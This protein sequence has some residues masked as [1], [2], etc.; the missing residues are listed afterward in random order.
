V[1]Q[2][3]FFTESTVAQHVK[4]GKL[5]ALAVVADERSTAF[6]ELPT[7]K[8]AG[9]APMDVSPWFGIVAPAGTPQP[10]VGKLEAALQRVVD[11][12]EFS[13]RLATIGAV[14]IKGSTPASFAAEA[15]AEI[16]YWKKFVADA[17]FPLAE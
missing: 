13:Q 10:I 3:G 14:P 15:K 6:P 7:I 4:A 11:D 12:K 2:L 16:A 17:K 5:R 9:G 8:E 1:V